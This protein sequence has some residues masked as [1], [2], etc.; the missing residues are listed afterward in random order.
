MH[1]SRLNSRPLMAAAILPAAAV[2]VLVACSPADRQEVR[3]DA[4]QAAQTARTETSQAAN[5]AEKAIDDAALTAKVKSTLLADAQVK[6]TQIDVDS[7][8]GTVTL[9]G[10]V[11]TA[12]EKAR[13]EQLA[14]GVDGVR[15]VRNNLAAP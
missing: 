7:N 3:R 12:T 2:L 10:S 1:N 15:A 6:G 8:Q 5:S 14:Q 4:D 13:A 11:S 9:S